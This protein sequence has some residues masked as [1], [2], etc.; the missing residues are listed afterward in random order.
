MADTFAFFTRDTEA[1]AAAG[2]VNIS[3]RARLE[4]VRSMS[5][6]GVLT[7]V[8]L[9]FAV[10]LFLHLRSPRIEWCPVNGLGQSSHKGIKLLL[11]PPDR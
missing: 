5:W 3:L 7:L 1:W 2:L 9:C 6:L 8:L 4:M 11:T 10:K